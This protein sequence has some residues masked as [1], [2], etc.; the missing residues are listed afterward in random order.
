MHYN[1]RGSHLCELSAVQWH[2]ASHTQWGFP[3]YNKIL[4]VFFNLYATQLTREK[5]FML[6]IKSLGTHFLKNHS[7]NMV[8]AHIKY[9]FSTSI[10]FSWQCCPFLVARAG[11]LRSLILWITFKLWFGSSVLGP[12]PCSNFRIT[13]ELLL[14]SQKHS[15]QAAVGLQHQQLPHLK[16]EVG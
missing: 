5:L 3:H 11:L 7:Q 6:H 10:L 16:G 13:P 2:L 4:K 9:F 15:R 12:V 8:W 14:H 1:E